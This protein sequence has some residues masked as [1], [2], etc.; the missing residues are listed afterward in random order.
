MTKYKITLEFLKKEH[1]INNKT[2]RVIARENN[3]PEGSIFYLADRLGLKNRDRNKTNKLLFSKF[4]DEKRIINLYKNNTMKQIANKIDSCPANICK[5]L[6]RHN[7]KTRQKGSWESGWNTKDLDKRKLMS[8][9]QSITLK[10]RIVN[11]TKLRQVY[12]DALKKG[13]KF[14]I[15][16]KNHFETRIES[17]LPKDYKYVGNGKFWIEGFNPDFINT[18]GCKKIIE[19]YGDYWHNLP[20]YKERDIKRLKMYKKYGYKTLIIWQHEL[21]DLSTLKEKISQFTRA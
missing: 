16:K 10:N 17:L 19:A 18:N 5:I 8:S 2:L 21:N 14:L 9:K 15:R 11:D 1:L 3:I 20:T 12:K 13:N 4:L 7:I 6:K